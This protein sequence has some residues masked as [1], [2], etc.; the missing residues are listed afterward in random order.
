MFHISAIRS[1]ETAFFSNSS[2]VAFPIPLLPYVMIAY[3][4][5]SL[6]GSGIVSL[7]VGPP[8]GSTFQVVEKNLDESFR[9]FSLY[10]IIYILIMRN[11][12]I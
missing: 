2:Q 5:I 8:K 6:F 1:P 10:E 7:Y 9:W 11:I 3:L 12:I 4:P